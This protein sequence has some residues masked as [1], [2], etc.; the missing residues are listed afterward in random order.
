MLAW[1]PQQGK[2]TSKGEDKSKRNKVLAGN[3]VVG[4]KR[5]ERRNLREERHRDSFSSISGSERNSQRKR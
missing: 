3:C 5:K 2:Q 4:G 1:K